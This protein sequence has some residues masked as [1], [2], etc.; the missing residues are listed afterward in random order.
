MDNDRTNHEH[1]STL[2]GVK[3]IYTTRYIKEQ[4]ELITLRDDLETVIVMLRRSTAELAH[5]ART[6]R[7]A[8]TVRD[9]HDAMLL[10]L[11]AINL[12]ARC[13]MELV[14]SEAHS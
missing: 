12:R 11:A 10:T 13:D 9:A 1:E 7:T 3:S 4:P 6:Q 14:K 5:T 2:H 8:R